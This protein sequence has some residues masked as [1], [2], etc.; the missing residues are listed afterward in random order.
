[1]V[2]AATSATQEVM[3]SIEACPWEVPEQDNEASRAMA[4]AT[5][6]SEELKAAK[7]AQLGKEMAAA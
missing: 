4:A 1:M 5:P 6:V 7:S 3:P 2:A